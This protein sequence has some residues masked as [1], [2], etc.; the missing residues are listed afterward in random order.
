MIIKQLSIFIENKPGRLA[1]ITDI[2]A[3]NN[4]NLRALSLADTA[5]FGILRI[6]V[7]DANT[8]EK[9]LKDN[10]LTV[11]VTSVISIGVGDR[12]GGLAE[13]LKKL[14][15]QNIGIEYMYA[16]V[17]K[18]SGEAYAIMRIEED[19]RAMEILKNAGYKG[20]DIE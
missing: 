16:F 11:S 12:P 10:G 4:I 1:E 20:L 18:Q 14:A 2:I 3:K 5:N 13:I 6:I 7:E 15:E 19:F 8:A 17:S 9:I